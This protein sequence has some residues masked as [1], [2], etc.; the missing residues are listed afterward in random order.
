[1]VDMDRAWGSEIALVK[2]HPLAISTILKTGKG[3]ISAVAIDHR[4]GTVRLVGFWKD[5]WHDLQYDEQHP[6]KWKNRK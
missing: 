5:R 6:G 1:M 2:T 4:N 3:G